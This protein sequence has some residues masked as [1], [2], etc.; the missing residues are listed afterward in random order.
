[1]NR[2]FNFRFTSIILLIFITIFLLSCEKYETKKGSV[3]AFSTLI[4]ISIT[5]ND[6]DNDYNNIVDII[7]NIHKLCD[8]FEEYDGINNIYTLNKVRTN[9]LLDPELVDLLKY[10]DNKKEET[11]GYFNHYIGSLSSIYKNLIASKDPLDI[12]TSA[13]IQEEL[14]KINNTYLSYDGNYVT[15]NGEGLL[16][17]GAC[18]KGYALM[19]VKEYLDSHNIKTYLI[20]GGSSS[21][22]V[23]KK[24]GSNNYRIGVRE[25]DDFVL[26]RKNKS[27]GTSSLL[28]QFVIINDNMYHHIINPKTGLCTYYYDTVV[29][30][31]DNPL[32]LDIYSTSFFVMN[33]AEIEEIKDNLDIDE[34]YLCKDKKVLYEYQINK[35][36]GN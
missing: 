16:D 36:I 7:N 25:V 24:E 32:D 15:L 23:G 17:L 34:V 20:N 1:M 10:L 3:Y 11:S 2:S 13:Q 18:A 27:L 33:K 22:I 14:N 28:E 31:G 12:P 19:K 6:V 35:E 5:S 26:E 30:V 8:N 29:L 9:V 4:D 21:I